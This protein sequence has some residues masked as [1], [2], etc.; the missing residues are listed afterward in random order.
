M[1]RTTSLWFGIVPVFCG[2]VKVTEHNHVMETIK[3]GFDL[4]EEMKKVPE[5]IHLQQE[6]R[7]LVG[8]VEWQEPRIFLETGITSSQEPIALGPLSQPGT[9]LTMAEKALGFDEARSTVESFRSDGLTEAT[10][11]DAASLAARIAGRQMLNRR[12]YVLERVG[13]N[14][15]YVIDGAVASLHSRMF[16]KT[17]GE[18]N[19]RFVLRSA[20]NYYNPAAN[21]FGQYV[22]RVVSCVRPGQGECSEGDILYTITRDRYG[23]GFRWKHEEYRVYSG[24]GGCSTTGH[25]IRSCNQDLQIMYSLQHDGVAN[26]YKGNIVHINPGGESGIAV[27]DGRRVS[28]G[29]DEVESMKVAVSTQTSGDQTPRELSWG[30][31]MVVGPIYGMARDVATATVWTDAYSIFFIDE[32][33]EVLVSLLVAVQDL[34]SDLED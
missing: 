29:H 11:T 19:P 30:V 1:V 16:I 14:S 13:G 2:R 21:N 28:V 32:V 7:D 25:G 8:E 22:F 18:E 26:V 12:D 10:V 24:T 5:D 4:L 20:F 6:Y 27:Q 34:T 9:T 15:E 23:R 17:A 31:G 3:Y 33:D